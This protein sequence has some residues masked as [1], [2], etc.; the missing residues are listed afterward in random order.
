M[1]R[2]ASSG[3]PGAGYCTSNS[4]CGNDAPKS[5]MVRGAVMAVTPTPWVSQWAETQRMAL[6]LPNASPMAFQVLVVSLVSRAI[7]GLP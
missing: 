1:T 7:I 3:E 4:A 5:W 6:G 2:A